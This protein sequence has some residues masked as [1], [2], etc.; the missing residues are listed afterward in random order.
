MRWRTIYLETAA[1]EM[2]MPSPFYRGTLHS[3]DTLDQMAA[4]SQGMVGKRLRHTDLTK[5]AQE[6]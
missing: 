3:L 1:W 5:T 6:A 2:E 4:I